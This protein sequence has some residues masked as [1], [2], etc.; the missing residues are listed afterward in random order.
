[1]G[2]KRR[3]KILYVAS[4]YLHIASFH[5]PY[6]KWLKQKGFIVHVAFK[7]DENFQFCEKN[8]KLDFNRSPFNLLNFR[9]YRNLKNLIDREGYDLIHCHTP[10]VSFL[11]RLASRGARK[12]GTKILYTSHGFHFYKGSPVIYWLLYY[13]VEK[14]ISRFTDAIITI[15]KEDYQILFERNFKCL[16]R[17]QLN[18]I[19]IDPNRL[20]LKIDSRSSLKESL[21]I[22]QDTITILYIAEFIP[23]KNHK[24][25]IESSASIV[26]EYNNVKF[27]FA[28]G[29]FL[30]TAMEKLVKDMNLEEYFHFIGFTKEIGNYISISDI[31]ISS[32]KQ[33][34]LGL[35]V[36]E[37]MFN[38]IPVVISQDRGHR[39][40][41]SDGFNG[42]LYEQN[43]SKQFVE[44]ILELISNK[45][46][47]YKM[48]INAGKSMEKFLLEN[49]LQKMSEIYNKYLQ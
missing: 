20:S 13:P 29:G 5:T 15:N 35:G 17:Y 34:G 30:K 16:D 1:M 43:D 3:K 28:G 6:L 45:D 7:G 39:E 40:L 44:R 38:K 10:M 49:S 37:I 14:W 41:V 33:E 4:T 46:L 24:F 21:D 11:T 18:G 25:I 42:F 36:A 8:W 27:L 26:S 12:K 22:D 9:I 2:R 48:G 47:R 19:G 31:G 23:R 32:S